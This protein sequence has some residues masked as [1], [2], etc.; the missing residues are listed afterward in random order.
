MSKDRFKWRLITGLLAAWL[1]ALAAH[2]DDAPSVNMPKIYGFLTQGYFK[3]DHNNYFGGSVGAGTFRFR[4]LGV[5]L[6]GNATDRLGF[7]GL[8][9]SRRAGGTDNGHLRM[10]HVM[11]DYSLMRTSTNNLGVS[12]GRLKLQFGL[13]ND[14]RDVA[15][16]RPSILLPQSFYYDNARKFLINADAIRI[17]NVHYS[18]DHVQR[19]SLDI[20]STKGINNPETKAYLLGGNFKGSLEDDISFAARAHESF[21]GGKTQFVAMLT[22]QKVHYVSVSGDRL[23][24][25]HVQLTTAWLSAQQE[26]GKVTLT[27]EVF[28]PRAKYNDFGPIIADKS[29]Y[30]L[31]YY[32]QAAYS[33]LPLLETFARYDVAYTDKDDRDGV[34]FSAATRRP[35]HAFYAK[36]V[37]IGSR[38]HVN[39]NISLSGEVHFIKGTAWLPV[40]DNPVASETKEKWRLLAFQATYTF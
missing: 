21:G 4:E 3:S 22:Y 6:A 31:G 9:L 23:P 20:G 28:L 5:G 36:D 19:F 10:D 8:L 1:V 17:Y 18:G 25:G 16:T 34:K 37:T 24:K 35:A 27:S 11:V 7:S 15:A 30:P 13:Y 26:L 14:T 40:V 33:P 32:F 12:A 2:A 29:N 38:Y 39:R